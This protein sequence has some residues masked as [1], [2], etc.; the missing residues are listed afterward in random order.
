MKAIVTGGAGFIGSHLVEALIT[1][2]DEVHIID[3]LSTGHQTFIQ[4]NA[5]FHHTDITNNKVKEIIIREKPDI[6]FHLAA[7]ADVTKSIHSP[8][9]DADVNISG[10]INLLEACKEA[11]VKQFIFSSTSAVYGNLEKQLINEDDPSIPISY[12]GLS[13]LTSE[14]YIKIFHELYGL[15]Y[16]I[17]RYGNVFGPR[18]TAKGEGGVIAVFLERMRDNLPI[19]VHGDGEQTRDFVYVEDVVQ[20]NILASVNASNNTL[21]VSTSKKTAVN[22]IV[23]KFNEVHHS[24]ITPIHVQA[25]QG[26]IKHSCLDN[27]KAK[28]IINWHPKTDISDGLKKTYDYCFNLLNSETDM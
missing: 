6:V 2:K 13:K 4:P 12:Y 28:R 21:H 5:V 19:N 25:R 1:R 16:T 3:N 17:L 10:T 23:Q 8:K 20:A 15:P 11:N 7:Q 18:Q 27:Q 24:K 9:F 26:D 14:S 22:E